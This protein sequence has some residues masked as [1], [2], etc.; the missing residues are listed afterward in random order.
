MERPRRRFDRG[1]SGGLEGVDSLV[2]G[3]FERPLQ[4]PLQL[5]M[6]APQIAEHQPSG[7]KIGDEDLNPG[8]LAERG[9]R[10]RRRD[11][12]ET[13]RH[14]HDRYQQASQ[15][16]R[17]T[18]RLVHDHRQNDSHD[19][20]RRVVEDRV[21]E[22]L[23]ERRVAHHVLAQYA[24][25]A[26]AEE[27]RGVERASADGTDDEEPRCNRSRSDETGDHAFTQ[28]I[29]RPFSHRC[30]LLQWG[31]VVVLR[32]YANAG[33]IPSEQHALVVRAR[34]RSLA[35]FSPSDGGSVRFSESIFQTPNSSRCSLAEFESR[36]W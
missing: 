6:L 24:D 9:L 22:H 31:A 3:S 12:V 16:S 33:Y 36:S 5:W 27:Y 21:A 34:V 8:D 15:Y 25:H 14:D 23:R 11:H 19:E 18:L 29:M 32:K 35:P 7:H 1:R 30:P 26:F 13:Q 4:L 20:E 17:R 10:E 28:K 2:V